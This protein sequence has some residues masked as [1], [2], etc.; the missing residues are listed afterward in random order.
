MFA[1]ILA[2]GMGNRLGMG[3]KPL[4]RLADRPLISYVVNA[5]LESGH[6]PLVIA[7][8]MTPLTMN[9]C[10]ANGIDYVQTSGAGYMED[11]SE[12]AEMAG[13]EGYVF[14]CAADLPFITPEII[15]TIVSSHASSA[16][17]ACSVWVPES[18]CCECGCSPGYSE[19]IN[20]V[21]ASP[22]GINIVTASL[23]SGGI[24]QDEYRLL[25]PEIGLCFNIN[26]MDELKAA[27]N[28]LSSNLS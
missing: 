23:L 3:E 5:F 18:L 4:V 19:T 21:P 25:L 2:G 10:R 20:G 15:E 22:A 11:I 14:T 26:T 28:F 27:E 17:P 12:A 24:E 9:W 16:M 13:E 7:S 8:P 1:L 6:E